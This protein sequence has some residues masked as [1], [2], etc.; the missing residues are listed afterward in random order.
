ML[1]KHRG[2]HTPILENPIEETSEP[3]LKVDKE[4]SEKKEQKG[5]SGLENSMR[6]YIGECKK[7]CINQS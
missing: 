5:I 1:W 2:V 7:F 3:N 4:L 6:K